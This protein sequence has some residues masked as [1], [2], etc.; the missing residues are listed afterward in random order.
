MYPTITLTVVSRNGES[1]PGP[2]S[3]VVPYII[4]NSIQ[5]RGAGAQFVYNEYINFLPDYGDYIVVETV[6]QI[7]AMIDAAGAGPQVTNIDDTSDPLNI[8]IGTAPTGSSNA[9]PVW[10]IKRIGSVPYTIIQ[11]AEGN[12]AYDNIWDDRAALVYS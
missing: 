7:W 5:S 11:W 2:K 10:R 12:M 3:F 8:Y 1:I 4:L 6:A 9:D